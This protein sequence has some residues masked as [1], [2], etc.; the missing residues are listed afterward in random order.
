MPRQWNAAAYSSQES[1]MLIQR[2]QEIL[3]VDAVELRAFLRDLEANPATMAVLHERTEE[4]GADLPARLAEAG[5]I[6]I[7]DAGVGYA[8]HQ[9]EVDLARHEVWWTAVKGTQLAKARIGKPM[10]RVKA[11]RLLQ[12]LIDRATE[13]NH[14]PAALYWIDTIEL[15]GSLADPDR[16]TV[17]DVDVR[18]L[19]MPRH[20][21]EEQQRR[22]ADLARRAAD[23]GR[24]FKSFVDRLL[25]A[26]QDLQTRLRNRSTLID[27][28]LD[29]RD[30]HPLPEGT[31]TVEVYRRS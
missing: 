5:Y 13:I 4:L 11:E 31:T 25:F 20:A 24:R 1:T 2:D 9:S 12:E 18:V 3:G 16:A 14:D 27:L 6:E 26:R 7:T 17:G 15:F 23:E 19:A 29:V 28:Q 21:P 10:S 8:L 22:E 30:P